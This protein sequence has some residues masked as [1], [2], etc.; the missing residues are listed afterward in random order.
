MR[1]PGHPGRAPDT[2]PVVPEEDD[3]Q[4]A[5]GCPGRARTGPRRLVQPE[6]PRVLAALDR[7]AD[8][9]HHVGEQP[10]QRL[11]VLAARIAAGVPGRDRDPA[12]G[13]EPATAWRRRSQEWRLPADRAGQ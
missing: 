5:E 12:G 2:L 1:R 8:R 6:I 7:I 10:G 4:R 3:E 9:Y 13:A 11:R